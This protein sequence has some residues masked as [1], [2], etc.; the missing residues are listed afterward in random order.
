MIG[1]QVGWC[2]EQPKLVSPAPRRLSEEEEVEAN[3]D[4]RLQPGAE[5]TT[6][7]CRASILRRCP[8]TRP[9]QLLASLSRQSEV[10]L[11][12]I[13]LPGNEQLSKVEGVLNSDCICSLLF[14]KTEYAVCKGL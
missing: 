10:R 1:L 12:F 8:S 11:K 6:I 14:M 5:S 3:P 7:R 2:P 9:I 13:S 4:Q